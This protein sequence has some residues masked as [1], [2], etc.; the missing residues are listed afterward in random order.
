MDRMTGL[1]G[2]LGLAITL[3][4]PRQACVDV[5]AVDASSPDAH[6]YVARA[7]N[8]TGDV[9]AHFQH[10]RAA[11]AGQI[12]IGMVSWRVDTALIYETLPGG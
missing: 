8:R 1:A 5:G 6:Q 12:D 7:G 9:V 2:I 3:G 11:V 4:V 10:L